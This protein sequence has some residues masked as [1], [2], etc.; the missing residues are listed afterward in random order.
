MPKIIPKNK[1]I[2]MKC[3]KC[4]AEQDKIGFFESGGSS[5]WDGHFYCRSC[6]NKV[7]NQ[8]PEKKKGEFAFY[9]K[10]KISNSTTDRRKD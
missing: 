10:K 1:I 9:A 7:F 6:F 3:S 4:L 2:E 5:M 8:L